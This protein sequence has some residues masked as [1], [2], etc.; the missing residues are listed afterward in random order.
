LDASTFADS[1]AVNVVPGEI[2]LIRS[3]NRNHLAV[4]PG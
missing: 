2:R 4:Q 3:S 1:I